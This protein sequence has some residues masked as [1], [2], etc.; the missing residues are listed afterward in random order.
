[1]EVEIKEHGQK[2]S[3]RAMEDGTVA[4]KM[5]YSLAGDRL[6]IIDHTEVTS[7]YGG[8]G[9]GTLLLNV[10]VEKARVEN[11]KIIPLCPYAAAQFNKREEIR[12]VMK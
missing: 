3:V 9:I 7:E 12:D 1:M 10:L 5:T 4:G 8:Q 11:K 6:I 2:G